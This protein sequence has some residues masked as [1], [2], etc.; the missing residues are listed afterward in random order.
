MSSVAE[1]LADSQ[2]LNYMVLLSLFVCMILLCLMVIRCPELLAARTTVVSPPP[3][4]NVHHAT[5]DN[6]RRW[7]HSLQHFAI[8]S[9]TCFW[10]YNMEWKSAIGVD[11]LTYSVTLLRTACHVDLSN[12]YQVFAYIDAQYTRIFIKTVIYR[13]YS[14]GSEWLITWIRSLYLSIWTAQLTLSTNA[15]REGN[16]HS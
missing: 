3:Q 11:V 1:R 14:W 13:N 7:E 4:I 9:L 2:G 10:R 5:E 6:Y 16:S 12:G 15:R 8:F